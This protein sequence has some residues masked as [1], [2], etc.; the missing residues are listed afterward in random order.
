MTAVVISTGAV[1]GK[2]N[3][4]QLI[5]MTI[6]ELIFFQISQWLSNTLL[7]VPEGDF[8]AHGGQYCWD[9]EMLPFGGL[10]VL[11]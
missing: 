7:K 8:Q 5:M 1:L 4:I 6:V 2:T 11:C 10:W 3:P 9:V